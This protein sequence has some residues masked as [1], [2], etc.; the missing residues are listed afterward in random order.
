MSS[1]PRVPL[2]FRCRFRRRIA[3]ADLQKRCNLGAGIAQAQRQQRGRE[4]AVEWL[5]HGANRCEFQ[6]YVHAKKAAARRKSGSDWR[7]VKALPKGSDRAFK[8]PGAPEPDSNCRTPF[9]ERESKPTVRAVPSGESTRRRIL[10]PAPPVRTTDSRVMSPRKPPGYG[11]F[12]SY[13]RRSADGICSRRVFLFMTPTGL[14][15]SS[16][17]AGA[18]GR[19][20]RVRA[21]RSRLTDSRSPRPRLRSF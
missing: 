14:Q 12:R 15:H 3:T 2:P 8:R 6:R 18:E 1:G 16:E 7:R 20:R 4:F 9:R 11:G 10:R 13:S 5:P 21:K 19:S 17:L